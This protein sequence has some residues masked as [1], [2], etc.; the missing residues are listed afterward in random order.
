MALQHLYS[1]LWARQNLSGFIRWFGS[2]SISSRWPD[3]GPDRRPSPRF[4]LFPADILKHC[5]LLQ[6]CWRWLPL[7]KFW[8]FWPGNRLQKLT[9]SY[10]SNS[11]GWKNPTNT[12]FCGTRKIR[13]GAF[14]HMHNQAFVVGPMHACA[15]LT[16]EL[17][18]Q[19]VMQ[20][21]QSLRFKSPRTFLLLLFLCSWNSF[22]F[23]NDAN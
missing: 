4:P 12:Y 18:T 2:R 11:Y 22:L 20:V 17:K 6:W 1:C 9:N 13:Q 21:V 8:I 3:P 5:L 16:A 15:V 19:Q 14:S 10:V 7:I 23:L